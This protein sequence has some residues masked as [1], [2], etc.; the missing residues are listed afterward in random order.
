MTIFGN[1]S[2]LAESGYVLKMYYEIHGERQDMDLHL[3]LL[4][5]AFSPIEPDFGQMLPIFARTHQVV[6]VE[7]QGHGHTVDIDRPLRIGHMAGDTVAL[8]QHL[9]IE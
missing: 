9:G 4:H 6:A 7:Q 5:G 3:V 1:P 2:T 8:L